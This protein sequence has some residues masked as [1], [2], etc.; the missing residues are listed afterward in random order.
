MIFTNMII[1]ITPYKKYVSYKKNT[2]RMNTRVIFDNI[3]K[4]YEFL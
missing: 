3:K 2:T 4:I 1:Y